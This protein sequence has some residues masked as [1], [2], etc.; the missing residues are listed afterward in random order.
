MKDTYI[1]SESQTLDFVKEAAAFFGKNEKHSTYT[2]DDIAEGCLFAMRFGQFN[3]C[4][5]VFKLDDYFEPI[6]FKEVAELREK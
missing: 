3:D 4:I 6:K 2:K 1:Q 5:I